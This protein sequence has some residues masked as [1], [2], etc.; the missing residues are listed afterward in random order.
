MIFKNDC[1]AI[2]SLRREGDAQL[3]CVF[4]NAWHGLLTFCPS[5]QLCVAMHGGFNTHFPD[6]EGSRETSQCILVVSIP[7]SVKC[8]FV[9]PFLIDLFPPI[10]LICSVFCACLSFAVPG[11]IYDLPWYILINKNSSGKILQFIASWLAQ[12]L[13]CLRTVL[14]INVMKLT[15][16]LKTVIASSFIFISIVY[17]ELFL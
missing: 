3:L 10:S 15:C 8:L 7:F 5:W 17:L 2:F 4:A 13:S 9:C 11:P 14:I 12:F 1:T 6:D 16:F